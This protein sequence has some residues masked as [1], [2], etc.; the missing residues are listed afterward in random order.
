V[1]VVGALGLSLSARMVS[2]FLISIANWLNASAS[3]RAVA[4]PPHDV[5][6]TIH[7]A[8]HTH[9]ALTPIPA[10]NP[11]H[12]QTSTMASSS[13]MLLRGLGQGASK[14]SLL[15][16]ITPSAVRRS[17][18]VLQTRSIYADATGK[19]YERQGLVMYVHLGPL[20]RGGF[21]ELG[22][23]LNDDRTSRFAGPLLL[24]TTSI[25]CDEK[26]AQL[27]KGKLCNSYFVLLCKK[28]FLPSVKQSLTRLPSPPTLPTSPSL[29]PLTQDPHRLH[30]R[31]GFGAP[32]R[33]AGLGGRRHE[34]WAVEFLACG[35]VR[36]NDGEAPDLSR[37]Q[38]KFPL[39]SFL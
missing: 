24:I 31:S 32:R 12:T 16:A 20:P 35:Q 29:P 14:H 39:A 28:A 8:Q 10:H 19:T 33:D 7:T 13:S 38:G 34:D 30:D 11:L 5:K 21:E 37:H 22:L 9:K 25:G 1:C 18:S 6:P 36:G 4:P 15:R 17:P 23:C 3:Q 26:E 27:Y 2:P